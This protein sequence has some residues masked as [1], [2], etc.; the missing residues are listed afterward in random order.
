MFSLELQ[1]MKK[2]NIIS[3]KGLPIQEALSVNL[4]LMKSII[5]AQV[6]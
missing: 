2:T 6:D 3:V 5:K 4:L 1:E